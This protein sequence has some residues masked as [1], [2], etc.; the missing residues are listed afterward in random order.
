MPS[1]SYGASEKGDKRA[2]Q[3]GEN[4]YADGEDSPLSRRLE[5]VATTLS[6]LEDH[7]IPVQ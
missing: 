7:M 2:C 1:D 6:L 3:D 4:A 5:F